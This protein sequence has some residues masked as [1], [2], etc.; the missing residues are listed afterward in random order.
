MPPEPVSA[1]TS[2]SLTPPVMLA[3][4]ITVVFRLTGP[5]PPT[6]YSAIPPLRPVEA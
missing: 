2:R 3:G 4:K 1:I 5:S 6:I